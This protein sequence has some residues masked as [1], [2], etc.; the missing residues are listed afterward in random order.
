[1]PNACW[2]FRVETALAETD[3][4]PP[5]NVLHTMGVRRRIYSQSD[6]SCGFWR[7]KK[8]SLPTAWRRVLDLDPGSGVHYHPAA[9]F[10]H[11]VKG[12]RMASSI[13]LPAPPAKAVLR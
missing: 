2:A 9:I 3:F 8:S 11:H 10:D 1:M 4:C 13:L 12:G 7:L 6:A 5:Q